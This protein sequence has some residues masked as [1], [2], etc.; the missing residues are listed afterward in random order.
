MSIL[1]EAATIIHG[2]REQTYGHPSKNLD[3]IA[4]MWENYL[5]ARGLLD[6]DCDGLFAHDVA[7]MMALLKI[8]RLANNPYHRDSLVDACGYMALS[9][10]VTK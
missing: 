5:R 1:E 4:G 3:T 9:E 8:A 10:I 7:H 6:K 2:D